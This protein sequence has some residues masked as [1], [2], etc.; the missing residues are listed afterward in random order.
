MPGQQ[1]ASEECS[2]A[3]ML[4]HAVQSSTNSEPREE[5][6][7]WSLSIHGADAAAKHLSGWSL[8]TVC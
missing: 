1:E 5:L 7:N 3:R 6:Q 2:W 8:C 4:H